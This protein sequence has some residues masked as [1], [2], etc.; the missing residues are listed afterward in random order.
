LRGR[1]TDVREIGDK[2]GA[3]YVVEG[4]AR[5]AGEKIR[6]IAQLIDSR[7]G[8]H[9]WSR[10]YDRVV[11]DIFAVQTELTSE[12]VAHLVSYVR[13]SEIENASRRPTEN[14]Q[15]YDLVLRG[16]EKNWIER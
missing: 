7:S 8:A 3:G 6:V 5:R 13:V 2:L 4:S 9:I 12:I 11:N 10:S 15:A 14:M 16:R 1:P